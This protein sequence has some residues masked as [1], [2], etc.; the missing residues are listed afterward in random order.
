MTD[1]E[2]RLDIATAAAWILGHARR[3]GIPALPETLRGKT[4]DACTREELLSVV[5]AGLAAGLK[6]YPFKNSTQTLARIQRVLGFLRSVSFE[7]MLDVGSGRGVFLIPFL[8]A[9]PEVRVTA[10][11][12]LEKRVNF[13]NELADGGFRQLRAERKDVCSQPYPDGSFDVVCM[14]E[15]LEHIPDA[16]KAAACAV[17]MARK[18]V[19]VTVPSKPDSNPEHIHLLTKD[20]LAAMFGE[21]GCTRLHFDGVEGHL[22]MVAATGGRNP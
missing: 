5:S 19:A 18:Y 7:T 17:R 12:L 2:E 15:V 3:T 4:A 11:D 9:F 13:L 8:K 22:F 20:R 16:E 6:L 1:F 14:L 21:T 10:L